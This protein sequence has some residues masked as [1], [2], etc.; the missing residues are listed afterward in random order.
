MGLKNSRWIA[1]V[2][3]VVLLCSLCA[4][5]QLPEDPSTA[6]VGLL[7]GV[8]GASFVVSL[9]VAGFFLRPYL[10]VLFAPKVAE[11]P[12]SLVPPYPFELVYRSQGSRTFYVC[13]RFRL[14]APSYGRTV[15]ASFTCRYRVF[16]DGQLQYQEAVG[17]GPTPPAPFDRHETTTL[18]CVQSSGHKRGYIE[19]MSAASFG[20]RD[21]VVDGTIDLEE[22][23]QAL[24]FTVFLKA[25][26]P[27]KNPGHAA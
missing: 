17:Y 21:I 27:G 12:V 16:S 10:G 9:F 14:R 6:S 25:G 13:L 20:A 18:N 7:L 15:Y 24:G 1:A 3:G 8:L 11:V 19:L 5:E 4:C 26:A 23:T 2:F 22:E